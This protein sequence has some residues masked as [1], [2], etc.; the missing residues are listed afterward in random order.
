M[1]R[2]QPGKEAQQRQD[3]LAPCRKKVNNMS[4]SSPPA[5][6]CFRMRPPEEYGG[7][8]FPTRVGV[9][10]RSAV[11][12]RASQCL[13]HPRGGVSVL[14]ADMWIRPL[15]SPPAWGCFLLYRVSLE[16]MGVFP[17]RVGVFL[18]ECVTEVTADGL[19]HP[20]GGVSRY[21]RALL[22]KRTS[23]PPAWGCFC[24][25]VLNELV[26]CVFPTR[27]GVFLGH[28]HFL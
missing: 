13:P 20:R 7:S 8:V 28:L 26:D 15:S 27:V 17:T 22:F 25:S 23:S 4:V 5:W 14:N 3:S 11:R 12:P 21:S 9:F 24:V 18:V 16:I 6:G 10:L 1:G 2:R 19:P